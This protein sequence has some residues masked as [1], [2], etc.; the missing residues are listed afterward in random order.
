MSSAVLRLHRSLEWTIALVLA[1]RTVPLLLALAVLSAVVYRCSPLFAHERVGR[2]ARRFTFVKIRTLPP[3]MAR[4]AA[5]QA[6][7]E[8]HVPWVMRLLRRTHLDELPQLWLVLSGHLSLVG[9]RAEMAA[10]HERIPPV[11]AAERLSVRPGVTGLWQVSAHCDGLICD[12]VEYDRL[13]VRHRNPLL[14]VWILWRTVQKVLLGR[15][16]HLF[17]VPRWATALAPAAG[18]V[19]DLTAAPAPMPA[20]VPALADITLVEQPQPALSAP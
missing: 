16:I 17:E 18:V 5:K 20:P 7:D 9:P 19:I 12:R 13:Y 4:Y 8:V 11:A 10:L 3:D 15:R 2:H 6:I 14:D 1:V